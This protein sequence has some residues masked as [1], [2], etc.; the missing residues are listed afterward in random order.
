MYS[1]QF[2]TVKNK[3]MDYLNAE[4][5]LYVSILS[6]YH[7]TFSLTQVIDSLVIHNIVTSGFRYKDN[8]SFLN[9]IK[10]GYIRVSLYGNRSSIIEHLKMS[11]QKNISENT[12][13]FKFSSLPFLYTD[14]YTQKQRMKIFRSILT[15]VDNCKFDI[16]KD[17][18]G[19]SAEDAEKIGYYINTIYLINNAVHDNYIPRTNREI[20]NL[21]TV[22]KNRICEQL[23]CW[24]QYG[25]TEYGE[26]LERMKSMPDTNERSALE[27]FIV[28]TDY[29]NDTK[30]N[31]LELINL[32]Y[33][34]V[35]ASSIQDEEDDLLVI[36]NENKK[37]AVASV[38]ADDVKDANE[39]YIKLLKGA[40]TFNEGMFT[41][42][43]MDDVVR[44]VENIQKTIPEWKDALIKYHSRLNK[45]QFC[46]GAGY[47]IVKLLIFAVSVYIND[48]MDSV[49]KMFKSSLG[50]QLVT[51]N[52]WE[53]AKMNI[54]DG[55]TDAI[56]NNMCK[57]LSNVKLTFGD[58]M[59]AIKDVNK[60][61]E[62]VN[63]ATAQT[64]LLK[65]DLNK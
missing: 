17:D 12:S 6:G 15:A 37:L 24:S 28:G 16:K 11:L 10:R 5:L 44:E 54:N 26:L 62:M 33:N 65:Q 43:M 36:N 63:S 41:W 23:R 14:N 39:K 46:I 50:A 55:V 9:L 25:K 35:V 56:K 4:A 52:I 21:N 20:R 34:E 38:L 59:K 60:K 13:S 64:L 27:A 18:L 48:G 32:C 22:L 49:G 42:E 53:F 45:A 1:N 2:D 57:S 51:S 58:A 47:M 3:P 19:I 8:I 61:K 7:P 40:D 31:A 29:S 30:S